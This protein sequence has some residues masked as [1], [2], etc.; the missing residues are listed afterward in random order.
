MVNPARRIA[1]AIRDVA[2]TTVTFVVL[3]AFA[4]T[5]VMALP[6][7]LPEAPPRAA[8]PSEGATSSG[9]VA[10]TERAAAV[11]SAGQ[12]TVTFTIGD[13][14][15]ELRD[16]DIFRYGGL[17]R[18]DTAAIVS[19]Q[20]FDSSET[21]IV[22]T[23]MDFPD[24]LAASGLAGVRNA[25][26]LLTRPESLPAV[27]PPEIERLGARHAII[28]GGTGAVSSIV[29]RALRDTLGLEVTRV[30]GAD[31]YETAALISDEIAARGGGRQAF[32]ARGDL[33]PDALAASPFSFSRRAPILLVR[34]DSMPPATAAAL[35]RLR[36]S[37]VYVLGGVGAVTDAVAA[38]AAR[39]AGAV[40]ERFAGAD[41]YETSA[42]VARTGIDEGWSDG[43][44]VGMA[45]GGDFPDAL[46]GGAAAGYLQG[47]VVL[48]Q[49]AV[50]PTHATDVLQGC[51]T[52]LEEIQIY[53][54]P[55]AVSPGVEQ[56]V[57]QSVRD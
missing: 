11:P 41:R 50:L 7:P 29:E 2:G 24:A 25:P 16:V 45:T 57:V 49:T 20:V 44:T 30:G 32:I 15:A 33:F 35:S 39:S 40:A 53:G 48:T 47:V 21:V 1:A 52:T 42:I 43:A 26:I 13:L 23:G 10:Q 5:V 14:S 38:D 22:A 51:E 55:A 28:V 19:S 54:G 8:G 18:Y 4:C 12:I 34:P 3:F 17:D 6:A 46:C 37:S 9:E 31:R 36:P 56:A 27:V